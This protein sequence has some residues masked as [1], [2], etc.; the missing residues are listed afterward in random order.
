MGGFHSLSRW[1]NGVEATG[2]GRRSRT[3][4]HWRRAAAERTEGPSSSSAN[5]R[6]KDQRQR[7]NF[8]GRRPSNYHFH[9][10][11][12]SDKRARLET[13]PVRYWLWAASALLYCRRKQMDCLTV[14]R[15]KTMP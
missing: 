8:F 10:F 9:S 5:F 12:W 15:V 14:P 7:T 13:M 11:A 1:P 3:A 2:R 4:D 6:G